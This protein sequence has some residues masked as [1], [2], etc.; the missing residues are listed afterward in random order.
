M[1]TYKAYIK[2]D[3]NNKLIAINSSAFLSNT[4]GWTKID[5]GVGDKYHHA[6]GNYFEK[7]LINMNGTHNYIYENKAVRETTGE[8]KQAELASFPKPEPTESEKIA[9]YML[10]LD[11]RLSLQE[12]GGK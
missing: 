5:E 3:S 1:D 2:I 11:Y 12:L 7:P 8:E 10:D 4:T 9:K 6:Q